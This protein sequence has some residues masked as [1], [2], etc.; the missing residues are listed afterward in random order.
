M[1]LEYSG[2]ICMEACLYTPA[3]ST[4]YGKSLKYTTLTGSCH[5]HLTD[6]QLIIC[7]SGNAR[8]DSSNVV[9]FIN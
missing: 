5:S 7:D 9:T 8:L 3:T 6:F 2:Q 4:S 1:L